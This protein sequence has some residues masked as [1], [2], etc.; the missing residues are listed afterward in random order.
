MQM[1]MLEDAGGPPGVPC[2]AKDMHGEAQSF[3][4]P[5]AGV[6]GLPHRA[7][8]DYE[9]HHPTLADPHAFFLLNIQ[10]L[11]LKNRKE[12]QQGSHAWPEP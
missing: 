6:S 10:R 1:V 3:N 11:V 8:G 9:P 12:S 2:M 4:V 7:A 5:K